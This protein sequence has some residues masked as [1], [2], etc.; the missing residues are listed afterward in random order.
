MR[1]RTAWLVMGILLVVLGLI[2]ACA[3]NGSNS[4]IPTA[5]DGSRVPRNSSTAPSGDN[6][7]QALKWS[8][9]MRDHGVNVRDPDPNGVGGNASQSAKPDVL[10]PDD[11]KWK[12]AYEACRSLIPNGGAPPSFSPEELEQQRQWVQ[13]MRDH[14]ANVRD[15]DPN[16]GGGFASQSPNAGQGVT[17]PNT[18]KAAVEACKG[19]LP[20]KPQGG[21]R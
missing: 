4:G 6:Q 17:D 8:Q 20:N 12:A 21:G 19:K 16:G 11:P 9:C 7:E 18:M 1:L 10:G 2:G 14:G 15:P 3:R 5:G 13:C